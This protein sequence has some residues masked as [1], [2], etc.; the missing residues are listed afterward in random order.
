MLHTREHTHTNKHSNARTTSVT[1]NNDGI[2]INDCGGEPV[3]GKRP[4]GVCSVVL[5]SL[6]QGHSENPLLALGQSCKQNTSPL[7]IQARIRITSLAKDSNCGGICLCDKLA[8]KVRVEVAFKECLD[9]INC[10]QRE[11]R[12]VYPLL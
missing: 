12:W 3:S 9:L 5:C 7:L 11:F 10:C 8:E 4:L 2:N 1:T 6:C